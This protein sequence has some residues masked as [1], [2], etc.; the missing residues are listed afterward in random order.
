MGRV[1]WQVRPS[2]EFIAAPD[3]DK[4]K[5]LA[6]IRGYK[7]AHGRG[8]RFNPPTQSLNGSYTSAK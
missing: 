1:A 3:T 4:T 7:S 5:H 8:R 2:G 6:K